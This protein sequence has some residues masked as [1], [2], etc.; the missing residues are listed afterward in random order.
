[1]T[2]SSCVL[3][4]D[5]DPVVGSELEQELDRADV[6][7]HVASTAQ[8]AVHLLEENRY[9][10]IILDIVLAGGS[11]FDVL[12]HARARGIDAPVIVV[13]AY[14]PEYVRQLLADLELVRIIHPKPYDPKALAALV[15]AWVDGLPARP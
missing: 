15:L 12:Q 8:A 7:V 6:A 11:G 1:M 13:S 2:S 3:V 14:V 9:S 5:D 10:V 4:V